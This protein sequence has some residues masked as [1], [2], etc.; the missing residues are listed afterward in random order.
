ML[1]Q[2]HGRGLDAIRLQ[3]V[4]VVALFHRAHAANARIF[5][6]EAAHEIVEQ[7]L[8]HR[9]FGHAHTVDAEVLD[10]FQQYRQSR[11]KHRRALCVHVRQIQF[12]D[13]SRGDDALGESVQVVER[14]PAANRD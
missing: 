1:E 2:A 6:G 9:A 3:L 7:S 4:D 8:A 5:V 12:I 13:M 10:H 11:G 14:D